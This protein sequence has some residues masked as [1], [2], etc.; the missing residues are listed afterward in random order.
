M[1]V[2][3]RVSYNIL[4]SLCVGGKEGYTLTEWNS[5]YSD[6][7]KMKKSRKSMVHNLTRPKQEL[8]S[9]VKWFISSCQGMISQMDKIFNKLVKQLH[10]YSSIVTASLTSEIH[11]VSST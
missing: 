8:L 9:T 10:P 3:L 11:E 4:A 6:M 7:V 5:Y 2:W 1:N